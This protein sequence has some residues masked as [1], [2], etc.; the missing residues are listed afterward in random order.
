MDH[1]GMTTT[2]GLGR[3]ALGSDSHQGPGET[4]SNGPLMAPPPK[5]PLHS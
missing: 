5:C 1:L 3:A 4:H 2:E